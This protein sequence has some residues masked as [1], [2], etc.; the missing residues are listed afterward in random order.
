M[1]PRFGQVREVWPPDRSSVSAARRIFFFFRF[2]GHGIIVLPVR[3]YYRSVHR[4]VPRRDA[5]RYAQAYV[6]RCL[7][8]LHRLGET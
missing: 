4:A 3:E 6:T 2:L 8:A 5:A 7:R 1:P